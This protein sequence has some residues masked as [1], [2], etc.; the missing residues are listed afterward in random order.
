MTLSSF[1]CPQSSAW[2]WFLIAFVLF[3]GV[4]TAMLAWAAVFRVAQARWAASV[5]RIAQ[6]AIYFTPFSVLVLLPVLVGV[7]CCAPWAGH[8]VPGKEAWL[9]VPFFVIREIVCLGALW[10]LCFLMVRWSLNADAKSARGEPITHRDHHRLNAISVA[11]IMV[12]C[13]VSSVVA[14]DFIMS[15]DPEWVS[16]M[17]APYFFCTNLYAGMAV[18]ILL[19]AALRRGLGAEKHLGPSQFHDMGNLLLAFS[20]FDMG[21][22]FAQYL[23][24]WYGNLPEETPFLVLRYYRGPWPWLGWTAFILGYAIPF[25]FLQSRR[26]K[27]NPRWLAPVAVLALVGFA[28]ERYVLIVPSLQP[29]KLLLFHPHSVVVILLFVLFI[30]TTLRFFKLYSP[31]SAADAAL[32]EMKPAEEQV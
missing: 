18:M 31:V 25:L 28:L 32:A 1:F 3:A 23:T 24:I 14:Y 6:S 10:T 8:P 11:V 12:Y 4:T 26:L 20:L 2:A 15:L 9:N 19:A 17:F 5:N 21:L 16:T 22:F 7:R 27:Q 30:Y 29:D 13:V